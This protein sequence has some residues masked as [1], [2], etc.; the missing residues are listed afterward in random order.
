MSGWTTN[1]TFLTAVVSVFAAWVSWIH[2]MLYT[3][4]SKKVDRTEMD[5]YA[6][7][8]AHQLAQNLSMFGKSSDNQFHQVHHK[9]DRLENR[10]DEDMRK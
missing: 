8:I 5:S 1:D 6:D 9:L 2:R 10:I 4:G 7:R 3:H